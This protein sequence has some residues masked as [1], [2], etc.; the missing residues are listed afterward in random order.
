M[1]AQNRPFVLAVSMIAAAIFI[2]GAVRY[3]QVSRPADADLVITG[4]P[5]SDAPSISSAGATISSAPV[6]Q[7]LPGPRP[8]SPPDVVVHVAGAVKKPGVYHLK[9]EDRA[10]DAVKSAGGATPEALLDAINLAA[11]VQDGEQIYVPKKG[12]QTAGGATRLS[13]KTSG[14]ST[15]GGKPGK[16]TR[17][18][19]GT[20]NINSASEAELMRLPGVGP[21]MASRIIEHRKTVGPFQQPDELTDVS[22]IGPKKFEKMKGF[23]RVR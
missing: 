9:A 14:R 6:A 2:P 3:Y 12:E 10:E 21:A 20:V 7:V 22:G 11:H 13:G 23:V 17:P 8:L 1:R 4:R 5:D 19:E 16:L 15:S 18:G